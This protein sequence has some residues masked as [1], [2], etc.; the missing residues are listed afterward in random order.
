MEELTRAGALGRD[1]E[2]HLEVVE[3]HTGSSLVD[4]ADQTRE[5]RSF[6]SSNVAAAGVDVEAPVNRETLF[7]LVSTSSPDTTLTRDHIDLLSPAQTSSTLTYVN[8]LLDLSNT[9]NA[10][11]LLSHAYTR[12]L[13]DLSGGQHILKKVSK[14]FPILAST[15]KPPHLGFEFYHFTSGQDL[16]TRFR[17][18]ME[19]NFTSL[20][21]ARIHAL[22]VEAN[23]AFDL[24]TEIFESLLPPDL[25]LSPQDKA[26]SPHKI[27]L[28]PSVTV[29]PWA[30]GEI[31]AVG[32]IVVAATAALVVA[33]VLG[34]SSAGVAV[35][36]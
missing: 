21:A 36:V 9:T 34:T 35:H 6:A 10:G 1:V 13:G 26:P 24:N 15:D 3:L 14:R 16:K 25:R 7:R 32:G 17:T 20:P 2:D 22:V 30:R 23:T 8:S 29:K 5:E 27:L 11:L 18:A 19:S 28:E 12:Y 4:L 31:A 33:S